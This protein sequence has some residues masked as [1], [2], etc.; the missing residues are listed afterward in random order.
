MGMFL[1]YRVAF[2]C[3]WYIGIWNSFKPRKSGSRTLC[4]LFTTVKVGGGFLGAILRLYLRDCSH[5]NTRSTLTVGPQQ[6][7][8]EDKTRQDRHAHQLNGWTARDTIT[9]SSSRVTLNDEVMCHRMPTA[10]WV[11]ARDVIP[12]FLVAS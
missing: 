6:A 11:L 12:Q 3:S 7:R 9:L 8:M 10:G 4:E 2:H 1:V 5:S